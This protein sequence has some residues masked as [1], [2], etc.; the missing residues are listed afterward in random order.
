MKGNVLNKLLLH[1]G[2]SSASY[3]HCLVDRRQELFNMSR[4]LLHQSFQHQLSLSPIQFLLHMF[5]I[6]HIVTS[7]L[8]SLNVPCLSPQEACRACIIGT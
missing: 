7:Y 5:A 4:V 6:I 1:Q 3:T 8:L 2:N